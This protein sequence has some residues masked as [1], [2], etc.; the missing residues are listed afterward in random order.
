MATRGP[1]RRLVP[2]FKEEY[3]E[4]RKRADDLGD[5]V[6]KFVVAS[7]ILIGEFAFP[8]RWAEAIGS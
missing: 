3:I 5:R 7:P 8:T 2:S 4:L 6:A 1:I